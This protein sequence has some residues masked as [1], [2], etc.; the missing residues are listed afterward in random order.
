MEDVAST[1]WLKSENLI[2]LFL[3]LQL[4]IAA[5]FST[6]LFFFIQLQLLSFLSHGIQNTSGQTVLCLNCNLI[7]NY[8]QYTKKRLFLIEYSKSLTALQI[9]GPCSSETVS[10][11]Q[12][13]AVIRNKALSFLPDPHSMKKYPGTILLTRGA[14][15]F[16]DT[17]CYV[18]FVMSDPLGCGVESSEFAFYGSYFTFVGS[19]AAS[20]KVWLM[21]RG[22]GQTA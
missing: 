2:G 3:R 19:S 21:Y 22:R 9:L 17:D 1:C 14:G 15:F 13:K 12:G 7:T 11:V 16:C 5:I 18:L 6:S 8:K 20:W 10:S 4:P